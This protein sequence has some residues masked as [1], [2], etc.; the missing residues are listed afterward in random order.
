MKPQVPH[1]RVGLFGIGIE[2]YCPQFQG[3]K[4]RLEGHLRVVSK[5]LERPDVEIINPGLIDSPE[6][7]MEAVHQ[8][9][10]EDVG[11]AA[12]KSGRLFISLVVAGILGGAGIALSQSNGVPVE[13]ADSGANKVVLDQAEQLRKDGKLLSG[14]EV[15]ALLKEPVPEAVQ[16]AAVQTTVLPARVVAA[17]A[18]VSGV[19]VGWYYRCP[20]CS[21]WHLKLAGGYAVSREVVVTCNHCVDPNQ[22]FMQEGF[23]VAVDS[24][25]RVYPVRKV[26]ARN[27]LMDAAILRIDGGELVPLA[28]NDDVAP[29]DPVFCFSDPLGQTGYF[30]QGIVNRFFWNHGKRGSPESV[31]QLGY[32][33]MNVSTEWAPGSSG[34]AILDACGNA[35]GHVATINPMTEH[36]HPSQPKSQKAADPANPTPKPPESNPKPPPSPQADPDRFNGSVLITLHSAIPARGVLALIR[37]INKKCPPGTN[38]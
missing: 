8:F 29:G 5:M 30:S 11:L 7:A 10:R 38:R 2:T 13:S 36:I 6:R 25:D 31:E 23:L 15:V 4:E 32:L 19:H 24:A 12:A 9:R 28:L 34:A 27:E 14:P 21:N 37:E 1:L 33:R 16:L 22:N 17:R 18:R 35:V 26:L 20:K 3:L